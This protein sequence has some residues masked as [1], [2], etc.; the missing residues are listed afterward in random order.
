MK[1]FVH[2]ALLGCLG[3]LLVFSGCASKSKKQINSLQAQVGEITNELV[4]LDQSVQETRASVQ[5][6]ENRQGGAAGES[7]GAAGGAGISVSSVYRTPSG[8]ELPS[9]DIQQALKNAGYYSGSIDGKIGPSTREAVKKFQRDNGLESDGV[10]GRRTW[11]KLK[12]YLATS[13]K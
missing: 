4:R 9:L 3:V 12:T 2:L 5:T 11:S 13:V 1:N 6:L 8:F 10:I 7:S